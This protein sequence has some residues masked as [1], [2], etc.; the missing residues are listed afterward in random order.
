MIL[1]TAILNVKENL[2]KQFEIDFLKAKKYISAIKG[3]KGHTL[4]KCIEVKNK[5]L[6]LVDWE[7]VED[8]NIGFRESEEYKKWKTL[9]HHYYEPF[10]TVEHYETV[11][12]NK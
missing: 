1:E 11:I 12:E 5:Y 10:P 7:T 9:L 3:Y 4:R 8:H 2:E 6:L